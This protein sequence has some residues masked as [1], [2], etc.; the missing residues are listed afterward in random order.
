MKKMKL[1]LAAA[2]AIAA[3]T[4]TPVFGLT[5]LGFSQS[6]SAPTSGVTEEQAT[7]G[8]AS[9]QYHSTLAST[10]DEGTGDTFQVFSPTETGSGYDNAAELTAVTV[11]DASGTNPGSLT[12]TLTIYQVTGANGTYGAGTASDLIDQESVTTALTTSEPYLTFDLKDFVKLTA[13]N[14]YLFTLS[15]G[16]TTGITLDS[17]NNP[18]TYTGGLDQDTARTASINSTGAVSDTGNNTGSLVFFLDTVPV[19]EPADWALVPVIGT[20]AFFGLRRLRFAPVA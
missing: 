8:T 17:N 6:A 18:S 1:I 16:T 7:A 4:Q 12:Y 5:T 20:I 11:E 2:M 9:V 15:T 13:G 19:P 14:V 10:A 3:S